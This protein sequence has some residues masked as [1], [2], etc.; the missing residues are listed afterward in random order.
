MSYATRLQKVR[1]AIDAI[2]DG[3]QSVSYAGRQV[4]LANLG[5][6]R[7]LEKEYETA[8]AAE[9]ATST[10]RSRIIYAIPQ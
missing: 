2:L 6:L 4:T 3:A 1:D 7:E 10:G 5:Q 9:A 8:T